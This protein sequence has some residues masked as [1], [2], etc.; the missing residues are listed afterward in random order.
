MERT[1]LPPT[2][3]AVIALQ[4]DSLTAEAHIMMQKFAGTIDEGLAPLTRAGMR[5]RRPRP[6]TNSGT[7]PTPGGGAPS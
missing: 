4:E 7:R 6:D 2:T 1:V 3:P 5:S